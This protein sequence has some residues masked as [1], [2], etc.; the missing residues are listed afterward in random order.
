MMQNRPKKLF[1]RASWNLL[2]ELIRAQFKLIDH[3]SLLGFLWSFLGPLAMFAVTYAIFS[4]RF[5]KNIPAYPLYLLSG[6]I[7]VN[8]FVNAT[9]QVMQSF[10]AAMPVM[11]NTTA[12]RKVILIANVGI[13]LYK[14]LLELLFCV[15]LSFFYNKFSLAM[16]ILAIPILLAFIAFILGISSVLALCNCLVRDVEHLWILL[17]RVFFFI[18]PAFY[19]LKDISPWASRL[20][21]FANPLTPF[22]VSLRSLLMGGFDATSYGYSLLWGVFFFA[23]GLG[24]FGLLENTAVERA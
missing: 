15:A 10:Y 5:G 8:F 18:T 21:Y 13:V 1:T 24:A 19:E 23:L 6:I 20:V 3:N 7:L 17:S 9:F 16:S 14:F 2:V 22:V 12:P 11:L 4:V